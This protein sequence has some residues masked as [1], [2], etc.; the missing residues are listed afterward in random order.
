M[1]CKNRSKRLIAAVALISALGGLWCAVIAGYGFF[2]RVE[3]ADV[4]VVLGNYVLKDGQ[5]SPRLKARLD[6]GLA[7]YRQ[8][9]C[10]AVIVSGG[11][12]KDGYDEAPAMKRYLVDHGVPA[13]KVI[14]DSTGANTRMT[15]RNTARILREHGWRSAIAVSEYYHLA[16][17]MLAFS[18][19]GIAPT[20]RAHAPFFE[21]RD[22]YSV[23][24]DAAA[25]IVY[26]IRGCFAA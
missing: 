24:R 9:L 10:E 23:P 4:A 25:F 12:G 18:Q 11:V 19:N 3:K 15:A 16:R 21:L 13:D 5:P 2:D 26:W 17:C 1:Q 20:Y 8:G 14:P 22:A 6:K 7:L